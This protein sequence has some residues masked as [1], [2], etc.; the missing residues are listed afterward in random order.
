MVGNGWV[1][2]FFRLV[3]LAIIVGGAIYVF[4]R[5]GISMIRQKI[6]ENKAAFEQLRAQER[7]NKRKLVELKRMMV[8]QEEEC[9]ELQLKVKRWQATFDTRVGLLDVRAAARHDA[10]C[11]TVKMQN[12]SYI[13]RQLESLIIP[14]VLNAAEANFEHYYQDQQHNQEYVDQII[15]KMDVA[16]AMA[17]MR[18][19]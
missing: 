18:E 1:F 8:A 4:Y 10:I 6:A 11:K 7:E 15:E 5:Y 2:F 3:N 14:E 13:K 16:S 9:Q 17:R 12:Y 19:Q